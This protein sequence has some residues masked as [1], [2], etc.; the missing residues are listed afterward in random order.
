MSQ[1]VRNVILLV[2]NNIEYM[3]YNVVTNYCV[4]KF[5]FQS[6]NVIR[7]LYDQKRYVA[8]CF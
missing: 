8:Q 3:N 7:T 4:E 2:W 5:Y 6:R 1:T